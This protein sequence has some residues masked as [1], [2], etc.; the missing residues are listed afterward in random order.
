MTNQTIIP[1]YCRLEPRELVF[2]SRG[3]LSA[4]SHDV[5]IVCHREVMADDMLTIRSGFDTF[6]CGFVGTAL[7]IHDGRFIIRVLFAF[8]DSLI[9]MLRHDDL[10]YVKIYRG[11]NKTEGPGQPHIWISLDNTAVVI[12]P[13]QHHAPVLNLRFGGNYLVSQRK[14]PFGFNPVSIGVTD[15]LNPFLVFLGS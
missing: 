6:G 10:R 2:N 14:S 8:V 5:R 1:V 4:E 7:L 12:A 9:Y 11:F 3:R 13:I 15:A